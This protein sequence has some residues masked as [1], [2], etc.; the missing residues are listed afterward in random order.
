MTAASPR[1]PALLRG[2]AVGALTAALSLAA[3]GAAAGTPPA[4]AAVAQLLVLAGALAALAASTRAG[5]WPVVA[6]LSVGQALGHQ[7]LS[8]GMHTHAQV[9]P[10]AM[11]VAHL[12]AALAGAVLICAGERFCAALSR[13]VAA[14][15]GPAVL[16]VTPVA[17]TYR[18]EG[19][20]LHS[21][22]LLRASISHR[23]PPVS[24]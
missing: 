22:S 14:I 1:R 8:I 21:V 3:H 5:L 6:V 9:D 19:Q 13:T 11:L 24:A 15:T 10:A 23:G 18:A 12:A 17:L 7:L 20:P 2:G 4:G 16:R